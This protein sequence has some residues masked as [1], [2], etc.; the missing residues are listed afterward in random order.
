MCVLVHNNKILN[1]IWHMVYHCTFVWNSVARRS[2]EKKNILMRPF[3][4][5]PHYNKM[6]MM[7]TMIVLLDGWFLWTHE[8]CLYKIYIFYRDS[9]FLCTKS[10]TYDIYWRN[11]F[12]VIYIYVYQSYMVG[13]FFARLRPLQPKT[14]MI[15]WMY[16]HKNISTLHTY[17]LVSVFWP[18]T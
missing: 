6:M 16:I 5:Y 11:V 3:K 9:I 18:S 2:I 10:S 12:S 8:C 1:H 4:T 13:F 15:F 14:H 7:M 17:M